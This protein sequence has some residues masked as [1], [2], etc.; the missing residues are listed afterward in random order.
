MVYLTLRSKREIKGMLLVSTYWNVYLLS[1]T[2]RGGR[3]EKRTS[4]F[5]HHFIR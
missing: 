1:R 4:F 5:G 2:R 3:R